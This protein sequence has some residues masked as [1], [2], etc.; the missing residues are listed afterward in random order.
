MSGFSIQTVKGAFWPHPQVAD[1]F[2][3]KPGQEPPKQQRIPISASFPEHVALQ[4]ACVPRLLLAI[5]WWYLAD[6]DQ[7]REFRSGWILQI[8]ARDLFVTF[9]TA[10]LWDFLLYSSLSPVKERMAKYKFNPVYPSNKQLAHDISWATCATLTSSAIEIVAMHLWATG[11]VPYSASF[12]RYP[13]WNAIWLFTMP[14]WRI[15]HFYFIHR[16]MHP[17]RTTIVPDVGKLLYRQVHSLHHKSHNPT[18][19]SGISMHPVESTL[20]Y[21]AALIPLFFINHPLVF[22]YTKMDLT[23]GAL[24]G[25]CGFANPANASF[26]HYLHHAHFE[27]NYGENFVPLDY[28]F[29]TFDDG[30]KRARTD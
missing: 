4:F 12:W 2:A 9:F 13:A 27:V 8:I 23:M 21:T 6:V 30:S 5:A 3:I 11:K 18:A 10:G 7:A 16:M 15:C 19:F 20:Y 26:N 28:L 25:H 24:I 14:Y 17:W 29:G 22:L 1:M